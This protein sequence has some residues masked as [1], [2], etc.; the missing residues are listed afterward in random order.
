MSASSKHPSATIGRYQPIKPDPRQRLSLETTYAIA[1]NCACLHLQSAA[2]AVARTLDHVFKPLK[3][4]SGQFAIMLTLHRTAPVT[5]GELADR[6]AMDQSTATANLKPLERRSFV[7]SAP[8]DADGRA[9]VVSLT[10]GGRAALADA[11]EL[12]VNADDLM[13][14]GLSERDVRRLCN[15]LRYLSISHQPNELFAS[16]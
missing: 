15:T 2:R 12:W 10:A 11:V 6:L 14:R 4:T 1:Q 13:T 3:L 9:R 16:I 7:R 8:H 5:V